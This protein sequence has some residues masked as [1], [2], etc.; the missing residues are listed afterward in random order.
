MP[1]KHAKPKH[2][3]L[4]HMLLMCPN[5]WTTAKAAIEK[6]PKSKQAAQCEIVVFIR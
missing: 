4:P 3:A 6:L 5:G 1:K 2:H